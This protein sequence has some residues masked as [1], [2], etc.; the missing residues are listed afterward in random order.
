MIKV[1]CD[2]CDIELQEQ[3]GLAF[4]PPNHGDSAKYHLC[5]FC[6]NKFLLW[7]NAGKPQ[8]PEV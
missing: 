6:W 8:A 5:R 1:K 7:M 3:G 2:S 4:S